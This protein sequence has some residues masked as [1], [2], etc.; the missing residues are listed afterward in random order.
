VVV[1]VCGVG[2]V[3]WTPPHKYR[4]KNIIIINNILRILVQ[5]GKGPRWPTHLATRA[6]QGRPL[7]QSQPEEEQ[8]P[9]QH[10]GRAQE[11]QKEL[12]S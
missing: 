6:L 9:H 12:F 3:S 2:C 10:Q 5:L 11:G 1:V 4:A 8:L 7:P